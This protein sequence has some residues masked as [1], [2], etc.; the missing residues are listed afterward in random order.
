MESLFITIGYV[1]GI[2]FTYSFEYIG[3]RQPKLITRDI[4]IN[5]YHKFQEFHRNKFKQLINDQLRSYIK[6]GKELPIQIV[7]QNI[8]SE[9]SLLDLKDYILKELKFTNFELDQRD[10]IGVRLVLK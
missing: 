9:Q 6:I 2:L 7:Y 1:L 4:I 5:N 3:N 10:N 8:F